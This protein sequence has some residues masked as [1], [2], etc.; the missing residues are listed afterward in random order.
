M[1]YSVLEKNHFIN[2]KI[3]NEMGKEIGPILK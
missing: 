1:G 2:V 3:N